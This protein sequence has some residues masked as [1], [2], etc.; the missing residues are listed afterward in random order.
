[1]RPPSAHRDVVGLPKSTAPATTAAT[2]L[3][4][5]FRVE[6]IGRL[7]AKVAGA[8]LM[9]HPSRLEAQHLTTDAHAFGRPPLNRSLGRRDSSRSEE[10]RDLHDSHRLQGSPSRS[11]LH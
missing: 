9:S 11:L 5:Y 7:G 2:K 4:Q 3:I 6:V 8:L 1:M 10:I